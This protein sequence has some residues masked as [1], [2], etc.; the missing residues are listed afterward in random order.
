MTLFLFSEILLFVPLCQFDNLPAYF[1]Q[2]T[3]FFGKFVEKRKRFLLPVN[4]MDGLHTLVVVIPDT[5]ELLIES[6]ELGVIF[7]R[8]L[9]NFHHLELSAEDACK[10]KFGLVLHAGL[11]EHSEKLLVLTVIETKVVA[12]RARVCQHLAPC[13]VTDSCFIFHNMKILKGSTWE[14]LLPPKH[15]SG[16]DFQRLEIFSTAESTPRYMLTHIKIRLSRIKGLKDLFDVLFSRTGCA[17]PA[18]KV[19]SFFGMAIT[20]YPANSRQ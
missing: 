17:L 19:D 8:F 5:T 4:G 11:F 6:G 1:F 3:G 12:V 20:R 2:F 14:N 10:D 13:G 7:L 15:L 18:T 16:R 9:I